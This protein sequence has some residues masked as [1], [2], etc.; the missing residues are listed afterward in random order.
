M[1]IEQEQ[2]IWEVEVPCQEN[3]MPIIRIIGEV[4]GK[5]PSKTTTIGQQKFQVEYLL[6]GDSYQAL[7]KAYILA[8]RSNRSLLHYIIESTE[9]VP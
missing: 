6:P 5:T 1:I 4:R 3:N 2:K 9:W 7:M 8:F